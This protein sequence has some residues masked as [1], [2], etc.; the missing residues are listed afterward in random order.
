[1]GSLQPGLQIVGCAADD[2]KISLEASR[3][4]SAATMSK[5]RYASR[6]LFGELLRASWQID[7]IISCHIAS[8]RHVPAVGSEC[9]CPA[10]ARLSII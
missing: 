2:E 5:P 3:H 10:W 6:I 8:P 9:A 4:P 1:M 7:E